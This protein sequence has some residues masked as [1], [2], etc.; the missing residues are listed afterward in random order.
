MEGKKQFS[1][2]RKLL[3]IT[4]IP[5]VL[6]MVCSIVFNVK[7][8]EYLTTKQLQASMEMA[9]SGID[10]LYQTVSDGDFLQD[11]GSYKKGEYSISES[12]A[13]LQK[14]CEESGINGAVFYGTERMIGNSEGN[15]VLSDSI[16]NI[17]S[18]GKT[19]FDDS[20]EL[21]GIESYCGF[22]PL[23]QPSTGE[24]IGAI[25]VDCSKE[26][27]QTIIQKA[28]IQ[29]LIVMG[30]LL[31]LSMIVTI[32]WIYLLMRRLKK[33]EYGI[34]ILAKGDLTQEI[35]KNL[36]H[37]HDEFGILARTTGE[38]RLNLIRIVKDIKHSCKDLKEFNHDFLESF[39]KITVDVENIH[40]SVEEIANGAT[41][42]AI[43]TTKST[44]RIVEM[45]NLID[46]TSNQV[47]HLHDNSVQMEAYSNYA[48]EAVMILSE[49]NEKTIDSVLSVKEQTNK[50][51][52]SAIEIQKAVDMITDIASQTNLLSLNASIEAARAG[53]HGHGFSIVA[54]QIRS[55]SEQSKEMAEQITKIISKLRGN[56]DD[57]VT[58]MDAVETVILEQDKKI[59]SSIKTFEDLNVEIM[60]AI[61]MVAQILENEKKLSMVKNAVQNS[62]ESLA[63]IAEEN[64]A[65]TEETSATLHALNEIIKHCEK[66]TKEL[67]KVSEQ[68]TS[69]S[70]QF[71]LE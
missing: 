7:S 36:K 64:A 9:I 71:H 38:L 35:P 57:S 17:V 15:E 34:G 22:A 53:E 28:I 29:F 69:H 31:L 25:C 27:I 70:L 21:D 19:V 46:E 32:L 61:N 63:G 24:V 62:M 37:N 3:C 54:Q 14:F 20:K 1:I 10:I 13:L 41:S 2:G 49:N 65:S 58:L 51:H 52:E 33:I 55:L 47:S 39:S 50:T 45:G 56:S 4:L 59:K 11:N 8:Q 30:T 48:K 18:Q 5:L 60:D 12:Q 67:L 26:S 66:D 16:W 43:E 23:Y 42:Q 68:L 40:S 6:V 44:E